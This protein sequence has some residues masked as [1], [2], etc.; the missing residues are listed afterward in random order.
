MT[1][2]P[3]HHARW[4]RGAPTGSP[5][6]GLP[7]SWGFSKRGWPPWRSGHGRLQSRAYDGREAYVKQ[8]IDELDTDNWG[9]AGMSVTKYR[10]QEHGTEGK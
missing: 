10:A 5:E 2:L 8:Y 1:K 7:P 3:R 9:V 6:A 4:A